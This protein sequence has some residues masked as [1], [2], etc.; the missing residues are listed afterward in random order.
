MATFGEYAYVVVGSG[1]AE[2]SI[3]DLTDIDAG[4]VSVANTTQLGEGF[5]WAHNIYINEASETLYLALPNSDPG[6]WAFSLADPLNPVLSGKW[7]DVTPE[8]ACHD[9]QVINYT[10]GPYAGK[11]IAFCFAR[12]AG[13]KI[14]DVTNKAMMET[15]STLVYPGLLYCHQGWAS[16]DGQYVIFGDEFDG[17]YGDMRTFVADVSD[18]NA[19]FLARQITISWC[20]A[21][22]CSK[23]I[24]QP[25]LLCWTSLRRQT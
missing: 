8:V 7:V 6:L 10:S 2:L 4:I 1:A 21:I 5:L 15:L 3:I 22:E 20:A 14:I 16:D 9:V 17:S 18:L 25:G 23:R 19:P 11:E 12:D 13:L 24:T